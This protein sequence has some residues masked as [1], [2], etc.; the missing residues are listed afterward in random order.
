M[1]CHWSIAQLYQTFFFFLIL[2]TELISSKVFFFNMCLPL[3]TFPGEHVYCK[4]GDY[5]FQKDIFKRNLPSHSQSPHLKV[6][7]FCEEEK[8]NYYF[9]NEAKPAENPLRV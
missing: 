2:E 7:W 4:V 8:I 3:I 5:G 6:P 1:C 9:N